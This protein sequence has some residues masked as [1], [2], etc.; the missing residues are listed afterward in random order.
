VTSLQ[1]VLDKQKFINAAKLEAV[2]GKYQQIKIINEL[3]Q[4]C[5]VFDEVI[6]ELIFRKKLCR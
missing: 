3:L 1:G 5:L 6:R 2:N 4:V